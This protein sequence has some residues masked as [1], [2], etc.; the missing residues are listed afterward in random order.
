MRWAQPTLLNHGHLGLQHADSNGLKY[1]PQ[2]L[3][4]AAFGLIEPDQRGGWCPQAADLGFDKQI[5]I[6]ERQIDA[7]RCRF[8]EGF[9]RWQHFNVAKLGLNCPDQLL[10]DFL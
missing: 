2:R 3:K 5:E 6:E 9:L 1:R 8:A 4:F 7:R 10:N